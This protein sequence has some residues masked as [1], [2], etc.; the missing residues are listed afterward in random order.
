[1]TFALPVI[2]RT[3]VLA[4]VGL[5]VAAAAGAAHADDH[6]SGPPPAALTAC[7]GRHEGDACTMALPGHDASTFTGVCSTGRQSAQL[8]CRPAPPKPR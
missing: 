1:M 8:V 6:A 5:G 7:A 4:I 2:R 3:I